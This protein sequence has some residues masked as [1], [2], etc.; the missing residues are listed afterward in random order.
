MT[1]MTVPG[2]IAQMLLL[3][4]IYLLYPII[5]V[6]T[7]YATYDSLYLAYKYSTYLLT[8]VLTNYTRT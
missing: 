2:I 3:C 5:L 6:A 1:Q 8:T 7:S 4:R